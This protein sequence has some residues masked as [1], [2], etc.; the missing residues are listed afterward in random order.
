MNASTV[1]DLLLIGA[2]VV[3]V[4]ARQVQVARV[5]PRL[6]VL[7]PLVLAFFGIR[8][9]PAST[10]RVPAD[11]ALLAVSAALSLGLGVWRGQTIKVWRDADGTL[12]RQGSVLTLVLWGVL[13]AARGLLY[14]VGVAAGHREASGLGAVLVTLAL[15]FA[16]QN[17]VTALRMNAA[18]PLPAGQPAGSQPAE[19]A[20]SRSTAIPSQLAA[21]DR[22]H[23]RRHERIQ[24]RRHER[25]ER[26]ETRRWE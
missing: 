7:A 21:H 8:S 26:R 3:W 11:L 25:R 5:K 13:I 20:A 19:P 14:G 9:L 17:T 1:A 6:L 12:W 10:W 23:T 18:P 22:L 2:A 16:A 4:L 24:A 15:S